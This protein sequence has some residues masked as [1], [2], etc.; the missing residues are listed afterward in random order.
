M[1]FFGGM[2]FP[3]QFFLAFIIV[4]ALIGATAWA[5][6][7]FGAGRLG[8]VGLRGRQPRLAVVDYASVDA[9]RRLLLIRRDNVEHLVMIGGPTDVVVESNIVRASPALRD[10]PAPPRPPAIAEAPQRPIALPDGAAA[11]GAWTAQPEPPPLASAPRGP[12]NEFAAQRSELI[13]RSELA[14]RNEFA[15][16]EPAAFPLQPHA[17]VQPRPQ[18]ETLAAL[19]DEL[20]PKELAPKE[21]APKPGQPPRSR[22][23]APP[24]P[25]VPEPRQESPQEIRQEPRP[26]P[27]LSVAQSL[28]AEVAAATD[29]SLAE[30]AQRLE[31]ALRKPNVKADR[32]P[33][34]ER[35]VPMPRAP[36]PMSSPMP[37]SPMAQP[38]M[39][40][41][42]PD[43]LE[44]AE[45]AEPAPA[46][47]LSP[48]PVAPPPLAAGPSPAPV[49]LSPRPARVAEVKPPRPDTKQP[50]AGKTLY[51][52]LEQEMASLLGRSSA[53]S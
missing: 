35:A 50:N 16:P 4:L 19:A 1:G 14:Q 44:E 29:Q 20:A 22:P 7:R 11:N 5:V 24:R 41:P 34:S 52:S 38:P 39:P 2:P 15:Q 32:N 17:D 23:P 25:F 26:E 53:K 42:M 6:R 8:N 3:V 10:M 43:E 21:F 37:S 18:R 30:M 47:P 46:A 28:S 48:P 45:F 36:A 13:Q 27:R 40:A 49:S 33:A 12:R 51:D 31:A 9:R